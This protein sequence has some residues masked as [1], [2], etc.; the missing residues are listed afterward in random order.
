MHI[1]EVQDSNMNDLL[2]F[3]FLLDAGLNLVLVGDLDQAIYG[4]R[5]SS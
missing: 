4:F 3:H 1:D 2:L 5:G